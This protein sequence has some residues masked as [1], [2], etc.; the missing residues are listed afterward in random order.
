[1]RGRAR[2]RP[3][4]FAAGLRHSRAPSQFARLPVRDTHLPENLGLVP[5]FLAL[6]P[7]RMG[8]RSERLPLT[9]QNPG[10]G[11]G[12]TPPIPERVTHPRAGLAA[13]PEKLPSIPEAPP[14]TRGTRHVPTGTRPRI[15]GTSTKS[16][17]TVHNFQGLSTSLT[18]TRASLS[19]TR[20][21][22]GGTEAKNSGRTPNPREMARKKAGTAPTKT[23]S[24][25]PRPAL[26]AKCLNLRQTGPEDWTIT[27]DIGTAGETWLVLL[28]AS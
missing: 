7:V 5:V 27:S 16:A 26:P 17:G 2:T 22:L 23:G 12:P 14:S 13:T 19:G 28:G 20:R 10:L 3:P 6:V 8:N 21:N 11:C 1:M 9:P 24:G 25:A 15:S 4:P 18:G